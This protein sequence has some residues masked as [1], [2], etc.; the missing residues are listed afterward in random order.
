MG[1][2]DKKKKKEE[3]VA[4]PAAAPT[5]AVAQQPAEAPAEQVQSAPVPDANQIFNASPADLIQNVQQPA[6]NESTTEMQATGAS[7]EA[8]TPVPGQQEALNVNANDIV[9]AAN[10]KEDEIT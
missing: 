7:V 2:F 4:Q 9:E 8:P 3:T 10:T 1:L 5:E 6:A